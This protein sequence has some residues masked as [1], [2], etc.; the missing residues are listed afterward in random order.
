MRRILRASIRL[1]GFQGPNRLEIKRLQ[2]HISSQILPSDARHNLAS[3]LMLSHV[4]LY[5]FMI[6]ADFALQ[7]PRQATVSYTSSSTF[8][9]ARERLP[10]PEELVGVGLS[11][12]SIGSSF[13]PLSSGIIVASQILYPGGSEIV[14]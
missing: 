1:K 2:T 14:V 4:R 5:V 7:N 12:E 6:R 10:W 13:T 8:V 3:I 9:N 11:S